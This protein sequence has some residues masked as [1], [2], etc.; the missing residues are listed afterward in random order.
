MSKKFRFKKGW[1]RWNAGDEIDEFEYKRLP[2]EIKNS[3]MEE[4]VAELKVPMIKNIVSG[5]VAE[6]LSSF[7]PEEPGSEEKEP[8]NP[9]KR[10]QKEDLTNY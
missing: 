4:V 1:K 8:K 10:F 3:I 9:F 6:K 2:F 7:N 5:T